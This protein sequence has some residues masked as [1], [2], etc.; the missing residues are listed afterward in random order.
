[1]NLFFAFFSASPSSMFVPG[2]ILAESNGFVTLRMNDGLEVTVPSDCVV[3]TVETDLTEIENVCNSSILLALKS[4]LSKGLRVTR[5]GPNGIVVVNDGH[6]WSARDREAMADFSRESLLASQLFSEKHIHLSDKG[7]GMCIRPTCERDEPIDMDHQE[8][9]SLKEINFW[10]KSIDE[11]RHFIQFRCVLEAKRLVHYP[12]S[13][14]D[15]AKAEAVFS[16]F[17]K[18]TMQP[19][20]SSGSS[21]LKRLYDAYLS[22]CLLSSDKGLFSMM[23]KP[24]TGLWDL[25]EGAVVNLSTPDVFVAKL[26]ACNKSLV[27]PGRSSGSFS[28]VPFSGPEFDAIE[29]LMYIELSQLAWPCP[30][31]AIATLLRKR[32]WVPSTNGSSHKRTGLTHQPMRIGLLANLREQAKRLREMV[33]SATRIRTVF[34]ISTT[35][36]NISDR[37]IDQVNAGKANPWSLQLTEGQ[38]YIR[39]LALGIRVEPAWTQNNFLRFLPE[40]ERLM[41]ETLSSIR[42]AGMLVIKSVCSSWLLKAQLVRMKHATIKIQKWFRRLFCRVVNGFGLRRNERLWR[43]VLSLRRQIA[44]L[45][46]CKPRREVNR[47]ED[48]GG[49][50]V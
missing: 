15:R 29:I 22:D 43:E 13:D 50:S 45:T 41:N 39:Y 8:I 28:V 10:A 16:L 46:N 35:D 31:A 25:L 33:R 7:D 48:I 47:S 4:R 12:R 36:W 44:L 32:C 20:I 5:A 9:C 40:Q 42:S 17:I 3:N 38:F 30:N 23:E 21:S 19:I 14:L 26:C 2:E 1:M 27:R 24:L 18:E 49:L 11:I 34:E 37:L 6:C